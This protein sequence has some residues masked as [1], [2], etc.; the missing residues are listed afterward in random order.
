MQ[1]LIVRHLFGLRLEAE[2]LL[3]DPVLPAAL[4]GLRVHV[5]LLGQPVEIV[6]RVSGNGSGVRA[7]RLDDRPLGFTV[8]SNPYRPGAARVAW[9]ELRA[10][11]AN[12]SG[13]RLQVDVG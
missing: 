9:P 7:L 13:R 10:A 6:Y 4:D 1:S 8:D 11:L 5:E 3:I 12:G 2:A